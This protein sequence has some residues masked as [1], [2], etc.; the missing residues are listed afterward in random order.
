MSE[1][2]LHSY[3]ES[4]FTQRAL[5]VLGIKGLDWRWVRTPMLPPKDDLLA[6]TGGYRGT[7][8]MQIG[9]D[10]YI[11]S[12][13]IAAELERRFPRPSLF[14]AGELGAAFMLVKWS[15]A[16][17]R[18][19][20]AVAINLRS[21]QWPEVFVADRRRLFEDFDWDAALRDAA[22]ARC[23]FRAHA[24]LLDRQLADGRRFLA[25]DA[26][27]MMDAQ[28]HPFVWMARGTFPQV[29]AQLLE[30]LQ[31]LE[32]WEARVAAIGEGRR[33][34]I[35]AEEAFAAA[36]AARLQTS[37][38]LAVDPHDPTG[39]AAGARVEVSPDDTRRGAVM[40]EIVVLNASEIAVR[41]RHDRCGEV[42]VHCPRIGYRVT[43]LA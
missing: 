10:V 5:R 28:A 30:G 8:V 32:A 13:L 14:P 40:G 1:I 36:R 6:L 29:A 23:Q 11:D 43:P 21:S 19:A 31:H 25:G 39:L 17:F 35:A 3:D 33:T 26:P 15:D 38:A 42:V 16:F 18:S 37:L 9:A 12:Q 2:I 27:G 20:F 7:P 22:H 24:T 34:P 41:R 4:P